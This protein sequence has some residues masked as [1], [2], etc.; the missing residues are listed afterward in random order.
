MKFLKLLSILFLTSTF[1]LS[2]DKEDPDTTGPT[3]EINNITD[4]KAY[5]F[6]ETLIMN[7]K[8]TDQ[9]GIYEYQYHLY[10]KDDIEKGLDVKQHIFY[11]GYFTNLEETKTITL[12]TKGT[13]LFQEGDYVIEVVATDIKQNMSK[14]IK[15]IKITYP[16][17]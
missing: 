11:E 5:K 12:P 14:F 17:E 3:I 9:S 6:G 15:P 4:G 2:C 13:T 10:S 7:F 8:F 16:T 1:I